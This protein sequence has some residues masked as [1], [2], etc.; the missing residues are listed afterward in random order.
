MDSGGLLEIQVDCLEIA[1]NS[2]IKSMKLQ[3]KAFHATVGLPLCQK[4]AGRPKDTPDN[5]VASCIVYHIRMLRCMRAR[6]RAPR[7]VQVEMLVHSK[8][9][10]C[11]RRGT[12]GWG[13]TSTP[14]WSI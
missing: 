2:H 8:Q 5:V 4:C 3:T 11:F 14:R 6:L 1:K 7:A 12:D 9:P 13:S 10:R